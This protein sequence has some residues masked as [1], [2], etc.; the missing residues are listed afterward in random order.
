MLIFDT[1]THEEIGRITDDTPIEGVDVSRD[2]SE[3]LGRGDAE[4]FLFDTDTATTTVL[5]IEPP[6]GQVFQLA[7]F[8]PDTKTRARRASPTARM[9][10][11]DR[12]TES[13]VDV[14]LPPGS[15][16]AGGVP[17]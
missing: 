6:A 8:E 12:S 9:Q 3:V 10:L 1:A 4:L 7:L 11:W 13:P 16:A 14:A 2:G 17:T 15:V 5:P